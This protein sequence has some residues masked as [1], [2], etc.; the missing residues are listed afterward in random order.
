MAYLPDTVVEYGRKVF[1]LC[2]EHSIYFGD[3][4]NNEQRR[5]QVVLDIL[6][7]GRSSH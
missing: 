1:L 3:G 6:D 2:E 5:I 4:T 7:M